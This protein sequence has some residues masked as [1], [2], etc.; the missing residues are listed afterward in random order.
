MVRKLF[1]TLFHKLMKKTVLLLLVSILVISIQAQ[2]ATGTLS[3]KIID[4]N[5][6][7]AVPAATIRILTVEDSTLVTGASSSSEG[8]F[9]IP[10]KQGNYI[11]NISF[12]GYTPY[13]QEFTLSTA[14]PTVKLDT[15][16]L[17]EQSI[18]LDEAVVTA[19]PTEILVKGDTLEYNAAA[20]KV[21]GMAVVEDLLKQMTGVEIDQ[22]GVIKVQGKEIKKIFVDG[23]EFFSDDP[24]IASKNLPAGMVEKLQ[25]VDRKS[26]MEK[27]TGFDDGEEEMIINLTVR[28]NMKQGSFGNAF[29]GYG[30]QERYEVNALVNHMRNSDQMT[31]MGGIN[32]TN[33]A[34]ASDLGADMGGGGG[35]TRGGGGNG[36]NTAANT[37]FNFSKEVSEKLEV[38]GNIRYGNNRSESLSKVYT[39]NLLSKGDTYEDQRNR[40]HNRNENVNMDV[41]IEWKP[42]SMT[43]LTFR[44]TLSFNSSE[45]MEA[46]LFST[47]RVAGD[48]VNYGNADYNS[49]GKGNNIGGNLNINRRLGKRGR[50]ISVGLNVHS[51]DSE[52][53]AINISNTFYTGKRADDLLDQRI[54]NSN[55]GSNLSG[56]LSYVEPLGK[57]KFLQFSYNYRQGA[58]QSDKDTRTRDEEGNY[59]VF[60]TKYSKLNDNSSVNQDL[61][62]DFRSRSEKYNYS[63]G[64]RAYPTSSERKTYVGDSLISN[65]TQSVTNYSP[66]AQ[67]NYL[68]SRQKN[69]RF[70]YAGNTDQPSVNQISPVIDVSNPLNITYGNPD[71]KPA[72]MHRMNIR[73]Q[74]SMPQENR[75][76]MLTGNFNYTLNAI[77][78]SRFTDPETGRKENTFRNVNGNWDGDIRFI[79]SQPLFSKKFTVS[80]TSNASYRVNNGFSNNEENVSR[81]TN[82]SENL[83]FN[84]NS[85][86]VQFSVRG[87][88]SYNKVKNSLEGQQDR[89]YFNY[90]SSAY[91]TI[92]LPFDINIQSD[93]RY[94]TNSGYSDGFKQNETLWNASIEKQVLKQKNGLIRVKVY[95]ILQQ[96]S[97]IRRNV[98]SNF[99]RDTTTNTLTS[100]FIVHF[101][102]RFNVFKGGATRRDMR[103]DME[104]GE[105]SP[106]R[107]RSG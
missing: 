59:T 79:I 83:G 66:N 33:N 38:G 107:H 10:V 75:F 31:F 24:K 16:A 21:T 84:Y 54:T 74:N 70:T 12:V 100:Y 101:V 32:N 102:Y 50:S 61:G 71:L 76:H 25:V 77:V 80:S 103:R 47:T 14:Q 36:I 85:S 60:D 5:T 52:N 67:F 6:G 90:G 69:L 64:F 56:N 92:H 96:R 99:I 19:A 89:E 17:Q 97:N 39:Q 51:N 22:N 44:P 93:I 7:E 49:H 4:K 78:T 53:K 42:D 82:L 37:G 98:S 57:Q 35:R 30:S 1:S 23:K 62:V 45:S 87:N 9:L 104:R 41:R 2:T 72:F 46:D 3:G 65:I 48:T 63:F 91:T 73:Y 27:M 58:S 18:L 95:D 26:E 68:W 13:F 15:I 55:S 81:Q 40:S 28:P 11:A 105:G 43:T 8:T 106:S 88:I 29:A 94:S 20:Y 86:K 34:G